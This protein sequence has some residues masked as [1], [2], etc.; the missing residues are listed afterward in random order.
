MK[1]F[2]GIILTLSLIVFLGA[3]QKSAKNDANIYNTEQQCTPRTFVYEGNGFGGGVFA[4]NIYN[5]GTFSYQQGSASN[6][7]GTGKWSIQGDV[8]CVEDNTVL[9]CPFINY[10]K[11]AGNALIFQAKDSTNFMY[12]K[13]SDGDRFVETDVK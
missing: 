10:F 3:C 11:I 6:Y 1:R 12:I 13:L 2:V 7:F 5:D 8:L 9:G 4:I